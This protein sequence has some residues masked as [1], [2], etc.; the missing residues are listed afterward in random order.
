MNKLKQTV[1]R[2]LTGIF[3]GLMLNGAFANDYSVGFKI[4]TMG[5][6]LELNKPLKESLDLR[7]GLNYIEGQ[8]NNFKM[9]SIEYD[10][11]VSA[12]SIHAVLDWYPRQN[13][14][15]YVS[16]GFLRG[17]DHINPE[18]TPDFVF[19]GIKI[20]Q[21]L[22][23]FEV[24]LKV[25]YADVAPYIGV[26]YSNKAEKDKGW[27]YSAELGFAYLGMP[28]IG[29]NIIDKT[30]G[31]TPTLIPQEELDKELVRIK[32]KV[33]NYKVWPVMSFSWIY[34]F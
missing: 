34:R 21:A 22:D 26:G 4:G 29:F 19:R 23:H 2:I 12:T 6:G 8:V 9:G 7:F 1:L 24:N 25:D 5:L 31:K 13:K 18:P 27:Y 3:L 32:N 16:G 28:K 30:T 33:D 15:F 20:G 10:V 14:K 17:N 11:D